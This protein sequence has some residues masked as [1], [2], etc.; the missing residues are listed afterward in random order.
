MNAS[1]R[2]SILL[3]YLVIKPGEGNYHNYVGPKSGMHDIDH[4]DWDRW[5]EYILY[6]DIKRTG[7]ARVSRGT[8]TDTEIQVSLKTCSYPLL[9]LDSSANLSLENNQTTVM[10]RFRKKPFILTSDFQHCSVVKVYV[11]IGITS[12]TNQDTLLEQCKSPLYSYRMYKIVDDSSHV[13]FIGVDFSC[14]SEKT[15]TFPHR[16]IV[17]NLVSHH[18]QV[19]VDSYSVPT[20]PFKLTRQSM[21]HRWR[22]G[23]SPHFTCI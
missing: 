9:T 20:Q 12:L 10:N 6:K 4:T 14:C 8:I 17:I 23:S 3:S 22:H 15:C 11:G 16:V 21:I 19:T 18:R 1:P 13:L 7:Y 5:C 2:P